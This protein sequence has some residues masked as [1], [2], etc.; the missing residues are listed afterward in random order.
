[1]TM[2]QAAR[3]R[4]EIFSAGRVGSRI[5]RALLIRVFIEQFRR[6]LFEVNGRDRLNRKPKCVAT[7]GDRPEKHGNNNPAKVR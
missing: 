5:D 1:M 2:S 7:I 3:S 4:R 6:G